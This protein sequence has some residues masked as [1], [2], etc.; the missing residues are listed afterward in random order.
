MQVDPLAGSFA[1][2]T[3]YQFGYNNPLLYNDVMGDSSEYNLYNFPHPYNGHTW[4]SPGS[5]NHWSDGAMQYSDWSANGGSESFRQAQ[6]NGAILIGSTQYYVEGNGERIPT[7]M[8]GQLGHWEDRVYWDWGID[9]PVYHEYFV[10]DAQQG[11]GLRLLNSTTFV[12]DG[13]FKTESGDFK[14]LGGQHVRIELT[15]MN[16]LGV[17]IDLADQS[18]YYIKKTWLGTEKKV[19]TGDSHSLLLLPSQSKSF[20]FYRYEYSPI[21]WQFALDSQLSDPVNVRVRVY[22]TWIQGDP[23]DPNH[24]NKNQLGPK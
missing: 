24:P 22:S 1:S 3:P 5:G 8:S 21:L 9:G 10:S 16:I 17:Q 7:S 20:D 12:K 19:Y 2:M 14:F 15:N 23:I 11:P 4:I 6:A 13:E 18:R